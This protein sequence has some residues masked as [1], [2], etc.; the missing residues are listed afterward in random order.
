MKKITIPVLTVLV[1]SS[2]F[3]MLVA[4]DDED[5][6]EKTLCE[7]IK[8]GKDLKKKER[9][10]LS[11]TAD[12]MEAVEKETEKYSASCYEKLNP[13]KMSEKKRFLEESAKCE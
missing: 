4:S 8:W 6:E 12:E 13:T 7:C 11:G 10:A 3:F 2:F 1:I 5:V 9:E